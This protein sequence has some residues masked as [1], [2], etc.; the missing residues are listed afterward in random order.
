MDA[1]AIVPNMAAN[2]PAIAPLD[3]RQ[4]DLY[5][6][7]AFALA[8]PSPERFDFL[9][10]STLPGALQDLWKRLG[11]AGEFPG[12]EWFTNYQQYEAAY[13]ALFDV[14][15]PE[16]PVPLFESAHDKTHPAPE[17]ALENT[18]FYDVLGLRSDPNQA[19]PDYL[20]TQLEFLA[21]LRYTSE[22]SSDE[23]TAVSLARAEADF[24]QRHL[25][26]W[27]PKA[28]GKLQQVST[29]GFPLMMTLLARFLVLKRDG[30][31]N[32]RNL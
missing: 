19:V 16:P 32:Q 22:N 26:N 25:L 15:L 18:Y 1:G 31:R 30:Y 6:F 27:V 17:V 14:G 7:F 4:T 9:S 12:F 20:I 29:P 24:L 28:A 21:A 8:P 3:W 23:A 5:R 2:E 11:C 10:Q 13:I